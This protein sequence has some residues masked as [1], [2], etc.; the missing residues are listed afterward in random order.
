MNVLIG[1]NGAGK[2]NF[3]SLFRMLGWMTQGNLQL[4]IGLLG[5][6][7]GLLYQGAAV[8]PQLVTEMRFTTDVGINDYHARLFHAAGDTFVFADEQFRRF[9]HGSPE[10]D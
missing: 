3:V 10:P 4:H 7:N 1:A 9:K 8:T 2:S 6:A 5:G